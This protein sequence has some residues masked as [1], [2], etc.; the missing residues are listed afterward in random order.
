MDLWTQ[1]THPLRC[2]PATSLLDKVGAVFSQPESRKGNRSHLIAEERRRALVK[3]EACM[4]TCAVS[5][6]TQ[7]KAVP[8]VQDPRS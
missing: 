4:L 6:M 7:A 5:F 8:V 2:T 3:P 1:A